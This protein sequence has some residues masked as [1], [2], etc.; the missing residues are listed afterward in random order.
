MLFRLTRHIQGDVIIDGVSTKSVPL[1]K[2]R[3]KISVIP[4]D[5]VLFSGSMRYNLDPFGQY[6]DADVW[7]A[8]ESVQLKSVVEKMAG[9]LDGKVT[10]SGGNLSVGQRQL[11]CLA[12]AILR[13]VPAA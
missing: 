4:Q 1:E 13:C 12:R 7:S 5:P 3:E 9:G 2:L 6:S 11:V 8:L 10:E